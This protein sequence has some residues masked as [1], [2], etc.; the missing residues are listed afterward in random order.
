MSVKTTNTKERIV[1]AGAQVMLAKSFHGCGLKEI[2]AVAGVPKGSFYHYFKSKEDLGVA[3]IEESGE[4]HAEMIRGFV[5]NRQLSP[6]ERVLAYFE[7]MRDMHVSQG[8][9]KLCVI[10]K[11]AFEVAHLSEPMRL[12]IKYAVDN[13]SA[14]VARALAEARASGELRA[15]ED[16]E[17]WADFI[18]NAWEGCTLRMQIDGDTRALDQ[19]IDRL[20]AE[21]T[22]R[23]S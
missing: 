19:F 11:L 17:E 5:G 13:W 22:A 4:R 2:L 21:L 15:D 7:T 20:K 23:D 14:L 6:V 12:A 1:D 8:A 16:A 9:K 10:G 3:V 18:T